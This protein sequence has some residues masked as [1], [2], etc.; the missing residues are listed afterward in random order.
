[1]RNGLVGVN[2]DWFGFPLLRRLRIL[3]NLVTSLLKGQRGLLFRFLI[4]HLL[5]LNNHL[6][7]LSDLLVLYK[8]RVLF[9]C[10]QKLYLS[11]T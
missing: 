5:L 8:V 1:M 3:L 7:F 2:F 4:L 11:I 6:P 10:S 9:D